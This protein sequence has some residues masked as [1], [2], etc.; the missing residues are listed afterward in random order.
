MCRCLR[1]INA[2]LQACDTLM[3]A[4][5]N[6]HHHPI[7]MAAAVAGKPTLCEKPLATTVADAQARWC[8]F[9]AAKVQ[10]GTASG[11]L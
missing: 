8:A 4:A 5:E 1:N 3:I 9:A 11:T 7:A 2:L 6:V 10:L